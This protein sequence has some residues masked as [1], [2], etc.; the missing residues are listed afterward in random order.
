M[1]KKQDCCYLLLKEIQTKMT[2][3]K[4][5]TRSLIEKNKNQI[6]EEFKSHCDPKFQDV[7]IHIQF[8]KSD[9][10]EL[11]ADMD[12]VQFMFGENYREVQEIVQEIKRVDS[13]LYNGADYK[14]NSWEEWRLLLKNN[15]NSEF[16]HKSWMTNLIESAKLLQ[17]YHGFH[18]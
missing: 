12:G 2:S 14:I 3:E 18:L 8:V 17:F 9:D 7:S 11:R 10:D 6:I 16:V 15:E 1:D 13:I 5:M 4:T